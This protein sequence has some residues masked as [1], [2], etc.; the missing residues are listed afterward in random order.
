MSVHGIIPAKQLEGSVLAKDLGVLRGKVEHEPTVCALE[1]KK[2][3]N[4]LGCIRKR[5]ASRQRELILPLYSEEDK[6]DL[7]FSPVLGR[8]AS[9]GHTGASPAKS[10]NDD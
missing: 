5:V 1:E 3:N 10:H 6:T 2:V 8:Q 7:E 4:L 9:S